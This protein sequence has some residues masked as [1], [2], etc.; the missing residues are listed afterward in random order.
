MDRVAEYL[1]KLILVF[2]IIVSQRVL[3]RAFISLNE[4]IV[5]HRGN[6]CLGF[7]D[8]GSKFN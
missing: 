7:G 8:G 4:F 1:F 5:E 3:L 2:S 6:F